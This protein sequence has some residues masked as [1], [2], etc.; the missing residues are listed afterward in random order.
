MTFDQFQ[1]AI[2]FCT[3]I[4]LA[5]LASCFYQPKM[6]INL[7]FR[8]FIVFFAITLIGVGCFMLHPASAFIVSG[9]LL[10]WIGRPR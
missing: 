10:F 3:I 4:V 7:D 1:T 6:E 9:S 2:I 5:A 8:D